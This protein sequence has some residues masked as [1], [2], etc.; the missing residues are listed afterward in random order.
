MSGSPDTRQESHVDIRAVGVDVETGLWE[1][2]EKAWIS[3]GGIWA[4]FT[5]E[6]AFDLDTEHRRHRGKKL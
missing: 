2:K 4:G 6:M 5:Q 1:P 3:T